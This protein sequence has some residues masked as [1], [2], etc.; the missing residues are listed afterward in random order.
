MMLCSIVNDDLKVFG[1]RKHNMR[2][3]HAPVDEREGV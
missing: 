3:K 1:G 2:A